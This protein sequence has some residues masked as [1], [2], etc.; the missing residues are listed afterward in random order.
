[1][2]LFRIEGRRGGPGAEPGFRRPNLAAPIRELTASEAV[3]Q[4]L[5][6]AGMGYIA[7]RT[8]G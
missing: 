6:F 2:V 4:R 3:R 1:M 7:G 8:E 5:L